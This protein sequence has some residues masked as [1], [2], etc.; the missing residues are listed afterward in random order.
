LKYRYLT[1]EKGG[2]RRSWY[3]PKAPLSQA[4]PENSEKNCTCGSK[5][6]VKCEFEDEYMH[7]GKV[8]LRRSAEDQLI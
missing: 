2:V 7:V 6:R 5:K 1:P 8:A 3:L 4:V